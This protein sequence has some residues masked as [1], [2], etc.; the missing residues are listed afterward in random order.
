MSDLFD[1]PDVVSKA[2]PWVANKPEQRLS[3]ALDRLL[4]DTLTP[5]CYFTANHDADEGNRSDN[6]RLRDLNRGQKFGQLDW[7]VEQG[8]PHLF[9]RLELK[10]GNNDTSARQDTTIAA[11]TACGASPVVAWTLA[12]AIGGLQCEGFQ[13]Q[14][15]LAVRLAYWQAQLDGW[16]REAEAILSGIIV[17]KKSKPRKPPARYRASKGMMR[18]MA[19]KGI[20][21]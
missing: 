1:A 18:R 14:P 8:P 6:Q 12:E 2:K 13:F 17:K 16:D 21:I 10:R 19:G 7:E 3:V 20:R 4:S 5:P 11:C 9:R 15:N